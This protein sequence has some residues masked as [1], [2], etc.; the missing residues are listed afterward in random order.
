MSVFYV[1]DRTCT[2]YVETKRHG[3]VSLD[4]LIDKIDKVLDKIKE[5]EFIETTSKVI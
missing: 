1:N 4:D 5:E 2:V 3:R